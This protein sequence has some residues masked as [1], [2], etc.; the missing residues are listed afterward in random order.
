[1]GKTVYARQIQN[2]PEIAGAIVRTSTLP[3]ELGR[4]EYLLS[5]KTGTLTQNGENKL[6]H[7]L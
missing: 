3:E 2:D 5:D 6:R 4:I 1:M 7:L